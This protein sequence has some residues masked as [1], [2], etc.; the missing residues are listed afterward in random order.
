V[1][2]L[3]KKLRKKGKNRKRCRSALSTNKTPPRQ[4]YKEQEEG[5]GKQEKKKVIPTIIYL[6]VPLRM[7]W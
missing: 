1:A 6:S 4:H 3:D 7:Q 2:S 5:R